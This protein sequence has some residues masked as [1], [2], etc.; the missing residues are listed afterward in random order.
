MARDYAK[1]TNPAKTAT[2]GTATKKRGS[3][4]KRKGTVPVLWMAAGLLIGLFA[5]SLIYLKSD[6]RQSLKKQMKVKAATVLTHAKRASE[7]KNTGPKFDFYRILPKE[8]VWVPKANAEAIAAPEE[9]SAPIAYILQVASFKDRIAA[10]NLK[11][12]LISEGYPV[13]LKPSKPSRQSGWNK[14]WLGP[15]KTLSK[16]QDVQVNVSESNNLTGLIL[17]VEEK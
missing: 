10:D 6:H 15:Y 13:H 2:R 9:P 4:M 16:V 5:A 17:K 7:E 11:A 12:Q 14:V 3:P 1:K 8:K